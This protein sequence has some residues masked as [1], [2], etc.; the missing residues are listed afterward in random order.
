MNSELTL[1]KTSKGFL[2]SRGLK[3]NIGK[4]WVNE[5]KMRTQQL[6]SDFEQVKFT[7]PVF[8]LITCNIYLL[9]S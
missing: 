9:K 2:F 5:N 6:T 4:E 7:N 1:Q 3:G 8:L